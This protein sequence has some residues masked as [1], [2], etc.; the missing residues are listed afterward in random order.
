MTNDYDEDWRGPLSNAKLTLPADLDLASA[1]QNFDFTKVKKE[2]AR[3]ALKPTKA[4][5]KAPPEIEP[6]IE[7]A[8]TRAVN[9]ARGFSGVA[10]VRAAKKQLG[11]RLTSRGVSP[12]HKKIAL[13][14]FEERWTDILTADDQ[15]AV[16]EKMKSW[17]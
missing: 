16:I 15:A 3:R 8:A 5:Q 11:R 17:I 10:G 12:A 13:N 14:R 1:F 9:A 7:E 2:V 4:A 6:L